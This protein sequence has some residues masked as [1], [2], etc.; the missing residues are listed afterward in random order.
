[1]PNQV[2]TPPYGWKPGKDGYQPM[3]TLFDCALYKYNLQV[4]CRACGHDNI[5]DGPGHWWLC[6]RRKWSDKIDHFLKRCYCS[7]CWSRE[8][9]KVRDPKVVLTHK[10]VDGPLLPAPDERYWKRIV[11]RQ[12]S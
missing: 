1:M 2:P 9:R 5:L 7:K 8:R 6:E 3:R 11:N 12:R 10:P 4:T